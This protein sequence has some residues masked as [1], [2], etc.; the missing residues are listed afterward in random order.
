L[1][2]DSIVLAIVDIIKKSE[3]TLPCNLVD[4][5]I[6]SEKN[7]TNTLAK[8]Q[9]NAILTNIEL[10]KAKQIPICQDT[11]ILIFFVEIG[12]DFNLNFNIRDAIE[13]AV[14]LATKL[15]PLRPN[16][17]EPLTRLNSGTNI[18][19]GIPDIKYNF[20]DGDSLKITVAPKGAGSENMSAIKMFNPTEVE[21]IKNFI[22]E[23]VL[24][25]GG[26]PCPPI[27]L[28]IGIGGS[29]DKAA[30]LAKYALIEESFELEEFG[31]DLLKQINNLGIGPMGLGGDTTALFVY[32]KTAYC[33][34]A[35]LPV[36][37]NI[38]CWANRHESVIFK[39]G[40][41]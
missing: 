23:T 22:L 31:D 21:Q 20:V 41:K 39:G 38:Q 36:A 12:Q 6:E 2:Y 3:I 15:V 27:V 5:L 30:A 19:K 35:S 34:T 24:N 26:M 28:G 1:N 7:E 9:I 8:K 10:A 33:H 13:D 40:I 32:T 16:A 37:V 4:K 29:F 14:K 25:A 18:G 11:G 17:V